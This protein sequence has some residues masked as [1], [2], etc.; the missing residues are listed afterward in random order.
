MADDVATPRAD[1]LN[2]T[3]QTFVDTAVE[4][5]AGDLRAIVLY[6]SAAEGRLRP[7]SD[8]NLVLVLRSFDRARIDPLREPFRVA[9]AAAGLR[10][11]FLLEREIDHAA[12]AFAV[13]F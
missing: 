12:H 8:V 10:V 7:T 2:P 3:V 6:G 11:M 9:R 1:S 4:S 13:K 5:L